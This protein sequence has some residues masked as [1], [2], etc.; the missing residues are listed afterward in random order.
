MLVSDKANPN[1]MPARHAMM[2]A[3]ARSRGLSRP[4]SAAPTLPPAAPKERTIAD[5]KGH[6]VQMSGPSR[7]TRIVEFQPRDGTRR[8]LVTLDAGKTDDVAKAE[9]S[10]LN[11]TCLEILVDVDPYGPYLGEIVTIC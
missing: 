6:V 9:D 11:G 7:H 3:Q 10:L 5:V 1:S 4:S 8:M 2:V